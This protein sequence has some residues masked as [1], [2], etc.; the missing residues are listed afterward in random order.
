MAGRVAVVHMYGLSLSEIYGNE[1]LPFTPS[2][3]RGNERLL[4]YKINKD[5]VFKMI[6][7]GQYPELYHNGHKFKTIMHLMYK[8]T[9]KEMSQKY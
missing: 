4:N 7:R 1:E 8:L 2:L 3:T 5:E 6:V 9:L